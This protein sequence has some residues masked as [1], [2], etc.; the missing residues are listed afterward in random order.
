MADVVTTEP[1]APNGDSKIFGVSVRA[2][3]AVL[4]AAT[5]CTICLSDTIA[6]IYVGIKTSAFPQ[7]EVKEPLYSMFVAGISFF[8]GAQKGKNS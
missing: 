7:V 2:W 3:L 8:F 1:V 6:T 5:V 4:L